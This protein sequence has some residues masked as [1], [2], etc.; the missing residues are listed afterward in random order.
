MV[1][2]S[3]ST[4]QSLVTKMSVGMISTAIGHL[5]SQREANTMKQKHSI[6]SM[7]EDH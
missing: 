5:T 3:N 2:Q 4:I 7:L 6:H 1:S